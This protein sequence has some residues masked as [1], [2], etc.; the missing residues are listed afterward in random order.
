MTAQ[1]PQESPCLYLLTHAGLPLGHKL[2][3]CDSQV[4]VSAGIALGEG[5]KTQGT[6]S[7]EVK[8]RSRFNEDSKIRLGATCL[9]GAASGLMDSHLPLPVRP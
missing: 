4:L 3:H 6:R 9:E 1:S 5:I 8:G 7:T 2:C